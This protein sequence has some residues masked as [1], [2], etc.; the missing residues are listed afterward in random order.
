MVLVGKFEAGTL[1]VSRLNF[2]I[3][4]LISKELEAKDM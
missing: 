2:A 1:D 3:I 4:T